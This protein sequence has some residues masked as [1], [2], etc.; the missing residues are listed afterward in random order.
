VVANGLLMLIELHPP[1]IG[2]P[3]SKTTAGSK[4][5]LNGV[6]GWSPHKKH[7]HI[8]VAQAANARALPTVSTITPPAGIWRGSKP[9][10]KWP[11]HGQRSEVWILTAQTHERT[12]RASKEENQALVAAKDSECVVNLFTVCR[13]YGA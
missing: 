13:A 4:G 2:R 8:C 12:I 9:P 3:A 10:A 11:Q 1:S 5:R 7:G 6:I